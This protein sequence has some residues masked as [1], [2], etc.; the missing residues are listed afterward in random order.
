ME[1]YAE[2]AKPLTELLRNDTPYVWAERQQQSFERMKQALSTA[3]CLAYPDKDKE[4]YLEASFSQQS[5]SAALAQR[6]DTDKRVV[7]YASRPLTV[8]EI[9][10]SDSE[11][12]LLAT[13]WA[14][15]HFRSYIGGQQV[16]FETCHQPV[17]FLNSQRLR[18]GRVSNSRIAAWMM[19]LQGYH[20]EVKYAKNHKLPLSQGLAECQHCNCEEG[21]DLAPTTM[22]P[23][24][25]PSNHLYFNE[26]VCQGL[27]EVYVDGCAFQFEG[28]LRAGV[29]VVWTGCMVNEPT[30]YQ[31]G[32]KTSQYAE[33]AAALIA[34]QQAA[35]QAQTQLVICSDSNYARHSF[36][37]HF[38][39]WKTNGM[40]NARNKPVKHAELFLACD[41]LVTDRGMTVYWR[42]VKGHSQTS[43]PDKE[44]NDEADR[45]ARKG[46]EEGPVWEFH[47][48]WL[49]PPQHGAVNA[50]TRRQASK[51]GY[52]QWD[53]QEVVCLGRKPGDTDLITMQE[54]DQ[55]TQV[56]RQWVTKPPGP[57]VTTWTNREIQGAPGNPAGITTPEDRKRA[58]G[59]Q[60]PQQRP[61][62][63]GSP[64][65]PPRG[66]AQPCSRLA[67]RGPPRLQSHPP[68]PA[69]GGL[70]AL[71][72]PR[73]E[74]IHPRVLSVLP[75]LPFAPTQSSPSPEERH[76][77]PMVPS[78]SR[79]D[80]TGPQVL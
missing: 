52:N 16:T 1:D 29:G 12:A 19:V 8:V 54:Q 11:K 32:P 43:G 36:I 23:E 70:L 28:Q 59:V 57:R 58:T 74:D 47:P 66:D 71:H 15:E 72:E 6:Y 79:L 25:L 27:P 37:S 22:T 46:A 53:N 33:I 50:I 2:I 76:D 7:A 26:N 34:I 14:V 42:K 55:I 20:I 9:K 48:D 39:V 64:H 60:P 62:P 67:R 40:K 77:V 4:F 13:V 69:A 18:E 73:C 51:P 75:I 78:P 63:L 35:R 17:T 65:W 61:S 49:P 38:P 44:G 31:L 10:F 30:H 68:N 5:I 24:V 41:Q 21:Q 80:R 3:P 45:L 56:A